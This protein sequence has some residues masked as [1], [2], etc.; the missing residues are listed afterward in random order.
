MIAKINGLED[1]VFSA[2][3]SIQ[4]LSLYASTC[5]S[6]A[7]YIYFQYQNIRLHE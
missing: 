6:L 2:L 4:D 7:A 1:S 5:G 3:L